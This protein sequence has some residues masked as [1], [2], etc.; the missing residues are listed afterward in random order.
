MTASHKLLI[1]HL[2]ERVSGG[3]ELRMKH[4]LHTHIHI[5]P[6]TMLESSQVVEEQKRKSGQKIS[7]SED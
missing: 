7:F 1:V 6:I 3:Q 2:E 4:N 5:R